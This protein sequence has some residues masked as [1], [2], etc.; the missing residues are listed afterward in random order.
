MTTHALAGRA[1]L[2]LA[3]LLTMAASPPRFTPVAFADPMQPP[4]APAAAPAPVAPAFTPAP[5]PDIDMQFAGDRPTD[6][7]AVSLT[8]KVFS[9][10]PSSTGDGYTP[11]STLLNEQTKRIMPSAGLNLS[12]PLQ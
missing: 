9:Q 11:H 7:A 5:V 1:M 12:V 8:P 4:A 10:Q 3:A 6:P 2:L